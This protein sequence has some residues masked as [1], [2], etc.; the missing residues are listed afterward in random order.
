MF[1][2]FTQKQHQINY[3]LISASAIF[4]CDFFPLLLKSIIG[5]CRHQRGSGR[6][7]QRIRT[8]QS[9]PAAA[10]KQN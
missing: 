5:V 7:E 3:N 9:S 4:L 1:S 6:F 2:P 8:P 10:C